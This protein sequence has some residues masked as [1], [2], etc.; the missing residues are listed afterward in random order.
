MRIGVGLSIPELS[1]RGGRFSPA[2]LFTS[3][4]VGAWY[5]PSDYSS[6]F[7]DSAGTTAVTAVEQP[8]G[9]ML[10]KSQGLAGTQ[11]I[12]D[13]SFDS[14]ITGWGAQ[15]PGA[16]VTFAWNSSLKSMT[17]TRTGAG[18]TGRPTYPISVVSGT[19][20]KIT[21][22]T[23]AAGVTNAA[24]FSVTDAANGTIISGFNPQSVSTQ[25]TVK[26]GVATST[27]TAYVGFWCNTSSSV[28]ILSVEITAVAGNHA[29]QA[30]TASRPVLRARYNLLTYSEQFDNAGWT[31]GNTTVSANAIA[32]PDGT[33]TADLLYPSSSGTIRWIYQTLTSVSAI[34][35]RSVYAKAQNKS[36]VYIDATGAGTVLA[37][38]N[39]SSGTVGTVSAG[40]TATIT[41]VGSGWYR[42]TM[43]NSTAGIP[44]FSGIYGV[45]D[46]DGSTTVTANGTDGIYLWGAQFIPGSSAGTY[47]RIAAATDYAT[48]GFAPYLAFDGV[49]D[50]L[51]AAYVQSAYPLT[52][53]A[54]VN[55]DT[56]SASA[57]GIVSVA[58][59]DASYKQLRDDTLSQTAA[60]D[61]N[62]TQLVSPIIT[63]LGSKFCLAQFETSLITHQV[64]GGTATTLA[65]T[66]AF[67]T[68]ANIF[69]GKTRPAGLFSPARDYGVVITN[70]VLTAAE[71]DSLKNYMGGKMG[72]TL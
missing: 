66:N 57:T 55:N 13:P 20:Y 33:T 49:D 70:T 64:N 25:T 22:I 27:G 12:N 65:N 14:G 47:Q 10:D 59:S 48:T 19:W 40:Y 56:S 39:L 3:G 32:A 4:V 26:Y 38:F 8:V 31:K 60:M 68:S 62:A 54:G 18:L 5:D 23:N 35:T 50:F 45:A 37:Y 24:A 42:C 28:D 17:V 43:T 34:Y 6:L 63:A 1:T 30:T 71:K 53:T 7:Q 61:R 67:G 51:S 69:V 9:L 36:I 29:S 15:F 16:D 46:A 21:I 52:I 11:Q 2:S 72:V 58:V 41:A 44:S